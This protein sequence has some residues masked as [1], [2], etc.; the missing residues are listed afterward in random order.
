V[1]DWQPSSEFLELVSKY[2]AVM[3]EP[4]LN[5][6]VADHALVRTPSTLGDRREQFETRLL[7]TLQKQID[8]EVSVVLLRRNP[9][10]SSSEC[11]EDGRRRGVTVRGR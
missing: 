10:Q 11:G 8:R 6:L 7:D 2:D 5:K 4:Q 3:I 9:A 1:L